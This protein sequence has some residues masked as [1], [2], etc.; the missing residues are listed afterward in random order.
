MFRVF[1]FDGRRRITFKVDPHVKIVL[2]AYTG[3]FRVVSRT[4]NGHCSKR[5][6]IRL[7]VRRK[8]AT[9]RCACRPPPPLRRQPSR[10]FL[11]LRV[12]YRHFSPPPSRFASISV[13]T[14][15]AAAP[16]TGADVFFSAHTYVTTTGVV[17]NYTDL[18]DRNAANQIARTCIYLYLRVTARYG[19][20]TCARYAAGR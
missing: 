16:T 20:T 11:A 7:L 13:Y 1:L 17:A 9:V 12:F 15:G 2:R 14:H 18:A 19:C 5:T 8:A 3:E 4:S 10:A 6:G